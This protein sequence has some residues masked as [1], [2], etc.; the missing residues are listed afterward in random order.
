M[1]A[2]SPY[3]RRRLGRPKY[4]RLWH[5]CVGAWCP[6]AFGPSGATLYDLSGNHAHGAAVGQS[7]SVSQGGVGIDITGASG[8][9][10]V[11]NASAAQAVA[12]NFSVSLWIKMGAFGA[13]DVIGSRGEFQQ[14]GWYLSMVADGRVQ[15][16]FNTSGAFTSAISTGVLTTSWS[17]YC[18]VL[19]SGTAEQWFDGV[20]GGSGSVTPPTVNTTRP[21]RWAAYPVAGFETPCTQND[22]RL[23]NRDLT[24]GEIKALASWQAISYETFHPDSVSPPTTNLLDLRR[25]AV[26][27]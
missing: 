27:C 18:M 9:G 6:S 21:T 4:P 19:R 13:L 10:I 23:Y 26:V 12:D 25:R 7:Y 14:D 3:F 2:V 1:P 5:G 11:C 22:M 8:S 17:H 16:I 15:A 24:V 20:L